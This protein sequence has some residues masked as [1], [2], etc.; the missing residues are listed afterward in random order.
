MPHSPRLPETFSG[1][2]PTVIGT[3]INHEG[4]I[5]SLETTRET[6]HA[7]FR[8]KDLVSFLPGIFALALA[9]GGKITWLQYLNAIGFGP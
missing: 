8:I 2:E 3:L 1:N 9:L 4:R 5:S 6:D 7:P